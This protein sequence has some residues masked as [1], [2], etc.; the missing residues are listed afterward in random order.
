[1]CV[2]MSTYREGEQLLIHLEAGPGVENGPSIQAVLEEEDSVR[3]K[4]TRILNPLG[5]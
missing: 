3:R 2:C 5:K 1:M 4:I